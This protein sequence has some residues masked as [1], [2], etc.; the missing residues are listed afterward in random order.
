MKTSMNV[1]SLILALMAGPALTSWVAMSVSVSQAGLVSTAAR[2]LLNVPRTAV[3]TE[4]NVWKAKE[5][6]FPATVKLVGI[7]S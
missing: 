2:T 1:Y 5:L 3:R 4:D 6:V 7:P